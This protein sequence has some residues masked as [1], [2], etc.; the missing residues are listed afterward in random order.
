MANVTPPILEESVTP[1][2]PLEDFQKPAGGPLV[3]LLRFAV[4]LVIPAVIVVFFLAFSFLK[5]DDANK[6]AQVGVALVA[7]VLGV[8]VLYWAMDRVVDLLPGTA[9]AAV[10]PFVFVGPAMVLVTVYLVYPT[11]QT[12]IFS[13]QNA[14]SEGFV[15]LDNYV[16]IFTESQYLVAIR[17]SL[18]WVLIVPA[19]AVIIGLAFATLADR[20]G[21][22]S[23]SAAKSLIFLP[24]AISFVGASAVWVFMYSFRPEGFGEQIGLLNAVWTGL[25][26]QPVDWL[27]SAPLNN[28]FLMVIL[29]WLQTGFCMVILSSAIKSVP[30]DLLEAARIDGA[31]EWQ[32]FTR[33]TLPS[34]ASTITV[35]WTTTVITVWKVFDIVYVMTG[36]FDGTQV[37]AQQMVQEFFT[38]RNNG[39][40]AALAVLLFVAVI[41]VLIINVKRFRE[42]EAM[43]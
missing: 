40:G 34:V 12:T 43:R 13:F 37:V 23:E 6:L 28:L 32:V 17:N 30:D 18:L 33:V 10:R 21:K 19:A 20:L 31:T 38:N 35:V 7:G 27:G 2:R 26:G 15:G 22:R 11:V 24:M 36:G 1:Q 25:G 9:A 3:L 39:V 8:W 41:P 29:I 4:A 42:Q 5:S 14:D 16:R